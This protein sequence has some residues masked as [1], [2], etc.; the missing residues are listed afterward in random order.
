MASVVTFLSASLNSALC[1]VKSGFQVIKCAK[2]KYSV[3]EKNRGEAGKEWVVK[4]ENEK[5][6]KAGHSESDNRL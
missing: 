2:L 3:K 5:K 4:K 6:W 1:T